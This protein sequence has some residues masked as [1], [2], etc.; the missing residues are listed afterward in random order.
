M[1]ERECVECKDKFLTNNRRKFC[2]SA[3]YS[4]WYRKT[5]SKSL[6]NCLY[7]NIELGKQKSRFCSSNCMNLWNNDI[8]RKNK[9]CKTMEF[10]FKNKPVSYFNALYYQ[11]YKKELIEKIEE[12]MKG[13]LD[14][15]FNYEI[16]ITIMDK[17]KDRCDLDN[18][19][20]AIID[21]FST[22]IISD[23]KKI[24]KINAILKENEPFDLIHVKFKNI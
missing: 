24:K 4:Y 14:E 9:V 15:E 5:H 1:I 18:L 17:G 19:I 12:Q 6:T 22:L 2:S 16:I 8:K 11:S 13:T 10:Y 20:K 23:D 3:C 7:C 21:C